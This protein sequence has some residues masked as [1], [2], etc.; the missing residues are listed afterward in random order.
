[1]LGEARAKNRSRISGVRKSLK[2]EKLTLKK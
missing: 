1:M 2:G